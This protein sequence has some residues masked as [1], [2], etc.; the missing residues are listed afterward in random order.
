[1]GR[2]ADRYKVAP[3]AAALA[4]LPGIV[5]HASEAPRGPWERSRVGAQGS[6]GHDDHRAGVVAASPPDPENVVEAAGDRLDPEGADVDAVYEASK[7]EEP[8][9]HSSIRPYAIFLS[10][11][12]LLQWAMGF[13]MVETLAGGL[14]T[15]GDEFLEAGAIAWRQGRSVLLSFTRATIYMVPFSYTFVIPRSEVIRF[16]WLVGAIFVVRG[17]FADTSLGVWTS[18]TGLIFSFLGTLL[19]V[20]GFSLPLLLV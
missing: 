12:V 7:M 19:F 11:A 13:V 6:F 18:G 14:P 4:P 2:V 20:P 10:S 16:I 8:I 9:L 1:M 15:D 5:G 17:V 3:A